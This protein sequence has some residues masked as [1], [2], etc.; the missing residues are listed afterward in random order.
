MNL[1][2][3]YELSFFESRNQ[4]QHPFLLAE[5]EMVLKADE[6]VAVGQQIL[7]PKLHDCKRHAACARV[8]QAYGLHRPETQRVAP[9]PRNLFDGQTALVIHSLLELVK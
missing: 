1:A 8:V 7:L 3:A 9:A 6:V 2:E 5:L 4:T